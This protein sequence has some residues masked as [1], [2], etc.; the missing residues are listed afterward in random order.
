MSEAHQYRIEINVPRV[1][2]PQQTTWKSLMVQ[3]TYTDVG[4]TA[5]Y[6]VQS[7]VLEGIPLAMARAWVRNRLRCVPITTTTTVEEPE[8]MPYGS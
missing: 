8:S 2:Y 7:M 1:A 4:D 5:D 6:L 3:Q